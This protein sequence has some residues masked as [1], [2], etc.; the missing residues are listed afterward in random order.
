MDTYLDPAV[1]EGT[2]YLQQEGDGNNGKDKARKMKAGQHIETASVRK[3]AQQIGNKTAHAQ[4]RLVTGP[5]VNL[6]VAIDAHYGERH[7]KKIN[8]GNKIKLITK[9]KQ[10]HK[11]E[12]E[13]KDKGY[14]R[15]IKR[16]EKE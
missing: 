16:R 6:S 15:K 8:N 3:D 10:G 13:Q 1:K 14:H 2:H 5:T 4:A 7:S 9:R 12:Q 11:G